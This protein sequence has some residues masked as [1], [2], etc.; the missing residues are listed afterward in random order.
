MNKSQIYCSLFLKIE[1]KYKQICIVEVFII[2]KD[3]YIKSQ[4]LHNLDMHDLSLII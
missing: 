1:Y 2:L 3:T 4:I